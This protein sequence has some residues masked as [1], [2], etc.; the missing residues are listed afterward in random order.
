MSSWQPQCEFRANPLGCNCISWNNAFDEVPMLVIGG[1]DL[2]SSQHHQSQNYLEL[3]QTHEKQVMEE[4][5]VQ[6]FYKN[7]DA[8]RQSYTRYA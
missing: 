2:K 5:L 4:T 3:A 8:N 6:I 7:T 1:L